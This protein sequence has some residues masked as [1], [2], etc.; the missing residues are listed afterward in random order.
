MCRNDTVEWLLRQSAPNL[1]PPVVDA[2]LGTL[3]HHGGRHMSGDGHMSDPTTPEDWFHVACGFA[4][5]IL[6]AIIILIV[7]FSS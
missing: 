3:S 1:T 7:I 2:C 4:L 6:A 5:G